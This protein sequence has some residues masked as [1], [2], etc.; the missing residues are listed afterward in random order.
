[1]AL[2]ASAVRGIA[3]KILAV[4]QRSPEG[5]DI[6]QIRDLLPGCGTQQHLDRRLRTLDPLFVIERRRKGRRFVYRLVGPRPAGTWDYAEISKGLKS[7]VF[8][9]AKGRCQM[10]G[11]TIA[12]DHVKLQ[13][14]HRIPRSWGG[15]TEKENLWAICS[16]CNE[17]KKNYY[18]TFSPKLM[19]E[20]LEHEGVHARIASLLKSRMPDWVDSDLIEFVANFEDY[21]DDWRRR[22]RELR[23][24]GFEIESGREKRGRRSISRYRMTKSAAIIDGTKKEVSDA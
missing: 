10:C 20:V 18:A 6:E 12:E 17:G 2:R 3:A 19:R 11:A 1:M 7:A 4:L 21:Q 23:D 9:A 13:V 14:D 15:L 22:L 5:L 16:P 24:L 8:D